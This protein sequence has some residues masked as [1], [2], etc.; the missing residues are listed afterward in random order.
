MYKLI[1]LDIDGTLLNDKHEVTSEVYEAVQKAKELGVKIILCSG[2]APGGLEKYIND[3]GLDGPQDYVV[4]YNGELIQNIS[5][6]EIMMKKPLTLEDL[7][8]LYKIGKD[9]GTT[10]NFFDESSVYSLNEDI[11]KYVVLEAYLSKIPLRYRRIKDITENTTISKVLFSSEPEHLETVVNSIPLSVKEKYEFVLSAPYYLDILHP[12]VS[13]GNAIKK[14]AN[15]F[16]IKREE[17]MCIGDSGNDTS[18]VQY[19][20]LGVAMGNAMDELKKQADFI[21]LSNKESGVAHAIH[22][23]VLNR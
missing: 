2:R 10:V 1:G 4:A 8:D 21:T 13:K 5:T 9:L 3:L 6:R 14:L 12:E 19:A 11:S 15:H 16:N 23:F 17:V 22:K 20:G 18:M 7:R